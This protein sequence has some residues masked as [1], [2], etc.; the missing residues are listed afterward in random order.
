MVPVC[1]HQSA[2]H[3][4]KLSVLPHLVGEVEPEERVSIVRHFGDQ[5]RQGGGYAK[6]SHERCVCVHKVDAYLVGKRVSWRGG[7]REVWGDVWVDL[8]CVAF[9]P[10]FPVGSGSCDQ[11]SC[12]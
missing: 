8:P 6:G 2:L 10:A 4:V 12:A 5:R 1:R 7:E 9:Y 11:Y 3:P